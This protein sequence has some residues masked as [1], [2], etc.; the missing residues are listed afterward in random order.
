MTSITFGGGPSIEARRNFSNLKS[1]SEVPGYLGYIHQLKYNNGHTYGEQTH[2]LSQQFGHMKSKSEINLYNNTSQ[3]YDFGAAR[4]QLPKTNGGNRLT[5][6]MIPGYTGYIPSR[7]F[8]F[9]DTYK[10]ECDSCIDDFL[11]NK[12]EK[13]RKNSDLLGSVFKQTKHVPIADESEIKRN[14]DNFKDSSARS[15]VFLND[16]REFTEAPMPGYTGHIP[17][18]YPT[19]TGL[20]A[21]YHTITEKGLTEF[22]NNYL[23]YKNLE[24]LPTMSSQG[25]VSASYSAGSAPQ[26]RGQKK[27]YA[28]HGMVP[29][30]TGY[31]HGR[32]FQFGN[33]YG[34]TTRELPVCSHNDKNF[35]EYMDKNP[36]KTAVC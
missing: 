4:N 9:S 29:K 28:R 26:Q 1:G 18:I 33:T 10:V 16:K 12:S 32:K 27:I 14:L 31:V 3:S 34:N 25:D 21:R 36:P 8:N 5:E 6:K 15:A 23:R 13:Y 24:P 19:E 22:K 11:T 30:Y 20:G 35:G 7:K 17:R 2:L